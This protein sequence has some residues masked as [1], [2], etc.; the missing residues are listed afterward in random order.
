M[1]QAQREVL[2]H[3]EAGAT[4]SPTGEVRKLRLRG[5]N[6]LP[7]RVADVQQGWGSGPRTC[8]LI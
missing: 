3:Q 7:Q 6:N 8:F 2:F 1:H 4:I 5:L